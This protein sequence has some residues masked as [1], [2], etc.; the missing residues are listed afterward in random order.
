MAI[1]RLRRRAM[2]QRTAH[3]TGRARGGEL[4]ISICHGSIRPRIV[5][6]FAR[7]Q[8]YDTTA[9][10]NVLIVHNRSWNE[11]EEL[12]A[13]KRT[14]RRDV[15]RGAAI[16]KGRRRRDRHAEAQEVHREWEAGACETATDARA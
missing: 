3:H 15:G 10:R 8:S 14:A 2:R 12:H 1:A 6:L 11:E 4:S 9:S 16:H 5:I 7:Y 13:R